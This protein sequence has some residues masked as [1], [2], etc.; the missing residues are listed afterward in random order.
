MQRLVKRNQNKLNE[1]IKDSIQVIKSMGPHGKTGNMEGEA[2]R[3]VEW[4][5]FF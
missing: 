2:D 4:L 5:T 3:I 1:S